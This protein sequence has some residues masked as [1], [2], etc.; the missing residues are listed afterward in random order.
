MINQNPGPDGGQKVRV[1]FLFGGQ[2]AEHEVSVQSAKNVL[3]A[4]DR[5]AFDPLPIGITK[6]GEWAPVAEESLQAIPAGQSFEAGSSRVIIQPGAKNGAFV[7]REPGATDTPLPVDVVFP[8]LHGPFGEDG[9][10]QGLLALAGLPFV[11]CGVLGAAVGMDKDVMKRLLRDAGLPVGRFLV[12]HKNRSGQP[13]FAEA[14]AALGATLF[15]KPANL[16]SSVGIHK[17]CNASEWEG[18]LADAFSHDPK[19]I[20]EEFIPGR[21]IEVAVLG[22]RDPQASVAGEIIP[23]H[24]FYD[25]E[26]K[27]LDDNGARLDI[28]ARISEEQQKEVRSLAVR[29]F[30]TLCARGLGRVDF[31][32]TSDGRFLVNEIN[33]LPGFTKI[34]MYPKLWGA[35]GLPYTALISTLIHLALGREELC[36]EFGGE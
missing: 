9:T 36:K 21:E 29:V 19:V 8:I 30:E 28:P 20:V 17:V 26:A 35:T 2:S 16:G 3:A 4:L 31:F 24:D 6:S 13:G 10:V 27:Y 15:I 22:N 33:T 25:Y 14:T 32:L 1:A 34:S 18:A 5:T 7:L 23:S 12:I 11:G